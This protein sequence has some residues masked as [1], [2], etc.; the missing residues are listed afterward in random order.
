MTQLHSDSEARPVIACHECDLLQREM[1]VPIGGALLCNRCGAVL[2]K[3]VPEGLER[4][5]AFLLGAAILFV[6]SCVFPIVSLNLQGI[7]TTATLI[8]TVRALYSQG[9]ALMAMLVFMVTLMMPTIE[10]MAKLYLLIPTHL[11]YTPPGFA[12]TFRLVQAVQPWSMVDVFIIGVLVALVKLANLGDIVP[13]IA[14]WSFGAMIVLLAAAA[15]SFDP[16]AL[17]EKVS[18]AE[19]PIDTGHEIG[20]SSSSA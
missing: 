19:T 11:G 15:A 4:T 10:I 14:L 8:E 13:G 18:T 7:V 3:N 6:V 1:A 17:W 12:P 16:H 20:P 9:M 5:L 2:F